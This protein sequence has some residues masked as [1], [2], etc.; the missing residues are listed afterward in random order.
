MSN[1]IAEGK[2]IKAIGRTLGGLYLGAG[3]ALLGTTIGLASGDAKNVS[4]YGTTLGAAGYALGSRNQNPNYDVG[5]VYE[6]YQR[7]L[8]DSVEE[9]EQA[10]LE[11]EIKKFI[12]NE[13]N[14]KQIREY[15][16]LNSYDEAKSKMREY[17]TSIGAGIRD[18]ENL[19]AI[20]NLVD[21][22]VMTEEMAIVASQTYKKAGGKPKNMAKGSKERQHIEHLS[23]GIAKDALG[24]SAS[25]EQI[26]Q[27]A[28]IVMANLDIF[29]S[30]KDAIHE[31]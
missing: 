22:G 8:Y 3:G 17:S 9:Y 1:N 23:Q 14:Q 27:T 25:P 12:E 13:K 5:S 11:D 26:E 16:G 18:T 28:K 31:R 20:M 15:L 2:P 10:Q 24:S 21:D 30:Y 4:Q 6:E 29:G 7:G 19:A